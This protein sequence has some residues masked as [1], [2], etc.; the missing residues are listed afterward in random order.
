MRIRLIVP[1]T[2][3]NRRKRRKSMS[4][5]LGLAMVAALTPRDVEVAVTDE[6]AAEV[7]LDEAVDLVGITVPT[8]TAPRAYELADAFRARGVKVVLGG[9]HASTL[10]EEA[11]AHADAVVVGEAEGS[12]PGLVADARAGRLQRLYRCAE[13]PSLVGLPHPRR[14]LFERGAYFF[15]NVVQTSRGCPHG[16]SFCT[17]TSYFGQRLRCRPVAE[18]IEE[19]RTLD[20]SEVVVFIDDNLIGNPAH[21]RE[22]LRSLTPLGIRWAGQT[23][24]AIGKHDE[25]LALAAESGC[26]ALLLGFETLSQA[27]LAAAQKR[28][29]V[30]AEYEALV[31][32]VRAH[33]IALH[34]FFIFGLDE[35]DEGV[36]E[37]TL[38]FTEQVRLESA[39]FSWPVPYPGT[40]LCESLEREGR[41]TTRDWSCYEASPVYR[42]RHMSQEAL[43][44]GTD[45]TWREFYS[46]PSIWRRLGV[47]RRYALPLWALNLSLRAAWR[48]ADRS[49]AFMS[50]GFSR[51]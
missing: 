28:V 44:R 2:Q 45:W 3:E 16:C 30:V 43:K 38:R 6:N 37:R 11:A 33:G 26:I 15:G 23:S 40:A 29:N 25:L 48:D 10:P 32:K 24:L 13:R 39:M 50:P 8:F 51:V 18:V 5:P 7:E 19:I 21:A 14:D 9:I 1:A 22:L 17:V 42:P 36:F 49:G 20:L 41:I 31:Q 34:G 27:N 4:P 46:L 12:W 47:L 35:D